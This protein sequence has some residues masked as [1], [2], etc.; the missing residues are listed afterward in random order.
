MIFFVGLEGEEEKKAKPVTRKTKICNRCGAE[1]APNASA[2]KDCR[3]SKFAPRWVLAKHAV[4]RQVSVEMT[5]RNPH[6]GKALKRI[7]LAKW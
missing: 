1:N 4:N 7:T 3:S 5:I 6:Y 2:C